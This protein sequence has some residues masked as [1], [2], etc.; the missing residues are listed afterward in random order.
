MAQERQT[1]KEIGAIRLVSVFGCTQVA[2][3]LLLLL[4]LLFFNFFQIDWQFWEDFGPYI[5]DYNVV[6]AWQTDRETRMTICF[7]QHRCGSIIIG[8]RFRIEITLKIK[9]IIQLFMYLFIYA[10]ECD[11]LH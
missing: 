4:P 9:S 6:C 1:E 2:A 10:I 8:I 7:R 5:K 3:V 11:T